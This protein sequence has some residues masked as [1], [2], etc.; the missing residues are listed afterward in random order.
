M[1]NNKQI[2]TIQD[3]IDFLKTLD[4]SLPIDGEYIQVVGSHY[5]GIKTRPLLKSLVE[6][7]NDKYV[8]K[9]MF[10]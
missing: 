1:D 6:K 4:V 8:L 9:A 5:V 2:Y 10:Y 7:S 3:L